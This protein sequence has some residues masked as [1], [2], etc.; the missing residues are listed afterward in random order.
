LEYLPR[1]CSGVNPETKPYTSQP[2]SESDSVSLSAASD[3]NVARATR[4]NVLV[5]GPEPLVKNVLKL[6]APA[7]RHDGLVQSGGGRLHLPSPL[8]QSTVVVQDV[9]ALTI[10]EQRQLLEWLDAPTTRT[11]VISTASMP[12]LPRIED[13]TFNETLYY[14]LNTIY[15]DL[16][17]E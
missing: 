7:A 12:M 10:A 11:Q 9:D 16:F 13:R 14:R 6:V 17:E 2:Y 15:I 3:L 4:A 8:G 1:L 5:V